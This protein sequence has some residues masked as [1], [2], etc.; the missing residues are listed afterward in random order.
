MRTIYLAMAHCPTSV[1]KVGTIRKKFENL[2]GSLEPPIRVK[3]MKFCAFA[4]LLGVFRA[5][6]NF[7]A[8]IL[9]LGEILGGPK[10]FS[11]LLSQKRVVKFEILFQNLK[12]LVNARR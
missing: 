10:K 2:T 1:P 7:V 8:E 5:K 4:A 3:A 6:K 12:E 9:K 11:S